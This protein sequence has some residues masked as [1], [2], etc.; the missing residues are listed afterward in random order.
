MG[1]GILIEPARR[2][3]HRARAREVGLAAK[4][5]PRIVVGRMAPAERRGTQPARI[6]TRAPWVALVP[7]LVVPGGEVGVV[8]LSA[9]LE[10][11]RV[12]ADEMRDHAGAAQMVGQRSLPDLDR[13]PGL[14]E[15]I[16]RAAEQIVA[17]RHA[18][19]RAGVVAGEAQ[20][21]ARQAVEVRRG[22][23]AAA[24]RAQQMAIEAVEKDDHRARRQ[25]AAVGG[26]RGVDVRRRPA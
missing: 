19:Q 22:E 25:L 2:R 21:P 17:G 24:V 3:C 18:R 4:V 9:A 7:A 1:G 6:G 5:S 8:V 11:V 10:E 20:R 12:V 13:S 14:P 23:L 26:S 16:E 15:E